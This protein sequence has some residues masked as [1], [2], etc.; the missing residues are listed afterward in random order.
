[1]TMLEKLQGQRDTLL[2]QMNRLEPS[3]EQLWVYQELLYRIEIFEVFRMFQR[4]APCTTDAKVLC[5]HYQMMDAYIHHI[6][7]E[8]PFGKPAD[9]MQQKHRQTAQENLDK[10]IAAYQKRFASFR[11]TT[12]ELYGK[13]IENLVQTVLV[14]WI[15][16]RNCYVDINKIMKEE[17]A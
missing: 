1:M 14:A 11:P 9:D 4:T 10:V 13:E 16:R 3:P 17:A 2:A 6:A 7:A 12:A 8:R 15:Q 5:R